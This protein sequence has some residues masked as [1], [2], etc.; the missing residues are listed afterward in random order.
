MDISFI[1]LW[2][3]SQNSLV[4]LLSAKERDRARAVF[5]SLDQDKDG[6]ITGGESRRAQTSWFHKHSK[7]PQSCNVRW[8]KPV[9]VLSNH[10]AQG[11]QCFTIF[12]EHLNNQDRNAV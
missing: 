1:D 4:R 10:C 7:E 2:F 3:S 11:F 6:V 9:V 5:Q 12:N 8:V